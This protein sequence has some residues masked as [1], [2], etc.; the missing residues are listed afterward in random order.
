MANLANYWIGRQHV[1]PEKTVNN[2]GQIAYSYLCAWCNTKY[3]ASVLVNS[4]E[5]LTSIESHKCPNTDN[6]K[7]YYLNEFCISGVGNWVREETPVK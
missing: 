2:H 4:V 3:P 5:E 1:A 7:V 6:L